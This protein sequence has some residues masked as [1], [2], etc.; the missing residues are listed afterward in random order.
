M[1][2][3]GFINK[4]LSHCSPSFLFFQTLRIITCGRVL[5]GLTRFHLFDNSQITFLLSVCSYKNTLEKWILSNSFDDTFSY[6]VFDELLLGKV[7]TLLHFLEFGKIMEL[8]LY[9]QILVHGFFF[10]GFQSNMVLDQ[11]FSMLMPLSAEIS[12]ISNL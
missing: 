7:K 2:S 5:A 3:M 1:I 11:P 9:F 8:F 6:F 4:D 12:C 10:K